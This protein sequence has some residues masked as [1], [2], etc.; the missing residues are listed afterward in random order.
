MDDSGTQVAMQYVGY[1]TL[2]VVVV[3][4]IVYAMLSDASVN[5]SLYFTKAVVPC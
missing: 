3:S 2:E 1:D 5:D 4:L